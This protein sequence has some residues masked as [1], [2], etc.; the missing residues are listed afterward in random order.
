LDPE[1]TTVLCKI[2]H[3]FWKRIQGINYQV[4]IIKILS[5]SY[6]NRYYNMSH[7]IADKKLTIEIPDCNYRLPSD[8]LYSTSSGFR[9]TCCPVGGAGINNKLHE[10]PP[11]Q[12][13]FINHLHRD[14][15]NETL[16]K[17]FVENFCVFGKVRRVDI[18][19]KPEMAPY[20]M[21]FIHMEYWFDNTNVELLFH[22]IGSYKSFETRGAEVKLESG[23]YEFI[24]LKDITKAYRGHKSE[25][26]VP[27]DVYKTLK[28]SHVE[29]KDSRD[30]GK[31]NYIRFQ[32]NKTPIPETTMNIHQLAAGLAKSESEV[33]ALRDLVNSQADKIDLLE[34]Q[35]SKLLHLFLSNEYDREF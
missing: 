3:L 11:F 18:S 8:P 24:T 29:E 22:S 14:F 5:K 21:A 23:L 26:F 17:N 33:G 15:T 7:S 2:E 12:S 19:S 28:F 1:N 31:L 25:S 10:N 35:V 27:W 16:L 34:K 6:Q 32:E 30:M 9:A 13:L 4:N 20:S